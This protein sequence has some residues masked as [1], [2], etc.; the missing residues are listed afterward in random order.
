MCIQLTTMHRPHRTHKA[1]RELYDYDFLADA[2]V[3]NCLAPNQPRRARV[4]T[5]RYTCACRP[6]AYDLCDASPCCR[7]L[8]FIVD[9]AACA[10]RRIDRRSIR[11]NLLDDHTHARERKRVRAVT[12]DGCGG[13]LCEADANAQHMHIYACPCGSCD[14]RA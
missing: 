6:G 3:H 13:G 4:T 8:Q 14:N 11:T 12:R 1:R 7:T 2:R 10:A 5:R 9:V